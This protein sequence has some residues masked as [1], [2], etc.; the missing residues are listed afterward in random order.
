MWLKPGLTRG[1]GGREART[2]LPGVSM[3]IEKWVNDP[4]FSI[5]LGNDAIF[6]GSLILPSLLEDLGLMLKSLA[7]FGFP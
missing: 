2:E 6:Q 5:I 3:T 1:F 7:L 4:I